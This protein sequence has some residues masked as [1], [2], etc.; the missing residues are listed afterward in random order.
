MR[1][2]RVFGLGAVAGA[3]CVVLAGCGGGGGTYPVSGKIVF[4][5]G[6]PVT[7][8][9]ITFEP[10]DTK[11]GWAASG[12]IESDGSF[13]VATT[14][15]LN[16]AKPGKYRV[17]IT[18]PEGEGDEVEGEG[19]GETRVVLPPANIDPKFQTVET[20]SLEAEV[21]PESNTFTFTVEHPEAGESKKGG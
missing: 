3:A 16:G 21:K 1:V 18:P 4:A 20:T 7:A 6:Q 14:D 10:V 5:D 19:E 15:K 8:G 2:M 9:L 12:P 11:D 17:V 13:E